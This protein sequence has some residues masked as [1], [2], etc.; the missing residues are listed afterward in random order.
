MIHRLQADSS[1]LVR[2]DRAHTEVDGACHVKSNAAHNI[3]VP[4]QF[5]KTSWHTAEL[6]AA[7]TAERADL[8]EGENSRAAD[9]QLCP[10]GV[11]SFAS[12]KAVA[13]E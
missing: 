11:R 10:I 6:T 12:V 3:A 1:C 4:R 2:L 8:G 7:R 5:L 13:W 9:N